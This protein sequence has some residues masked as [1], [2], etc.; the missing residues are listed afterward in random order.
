MP[1][2]CTRAAPLSG[3]QPRWFSPHCESARRSLQ[4]PSVSIFPEP[5]ERCQALQ[6]FPQ[7]LRRRAPECNAFAAKNFLRQNSGLPAE[8]YAFLDA[9]VFADADLA[10][11]DDVIFDGDAAGEA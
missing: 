9:R 11:D 2:S 8:Q 3:Q 10:T 4:L 1:S 7:G 6:V 5:R